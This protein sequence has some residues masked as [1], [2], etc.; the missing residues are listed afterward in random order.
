MVRKKRERKHKVTVISGYVEW[1]DPVTKRKRK[2][3]FEVETQS[4]KKAHGEIKRQYPHGTVII[5]EKY[6]R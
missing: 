5:V 6:K 2:A 1:I 4:K 3:A